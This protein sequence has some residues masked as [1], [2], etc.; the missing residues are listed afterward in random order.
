M[1]IDPDYFR[2]IL[3]ELIEENPLACQGILSIA[4]I[5]FTGSVP[6]LAVPLND[7]PPRLLVNLDF[8]RSNCTDEIPPGL[9]DND[10]IRW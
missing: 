2:A 9:N 7:D 6:T 8:I 5:V 1:N 4:E 3:D 10:H